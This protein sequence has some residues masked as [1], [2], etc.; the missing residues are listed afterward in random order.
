[1]SW[2]S[3][4]DSVRSEALSAWFEVSGEVVPPI[5]SLQRA[6]ESP[7]LDRISAS[8][9]E[10]ATSP[11][12]RARILASMRKE[13]G[14]WLNALPCAPLGTFLDNGTVRIAASLRLGTKI[15]HP[16]RCRCGEA[17]DELGTHGLSCQKN[18]GRLA[19]HA[20]INDIIRRACSSIHVPSILEPSG[21]YRNDGKRPDGVT[22]MPWSKGKCLLWDAT[23]SDTLAKSYISSTSRSAGAA[24]LSAEKRKHKKYEGV[25]HLYKFVPFAVETLGPFG[26]EAMDLVK[27]LGRRLIESSGELRSRAYLTQRISIAIQRGNAASIFATVPRSSQLTEVFYL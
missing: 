14:A 19:R 12:S 1:M 23:C 26:D 7:T 3:H 24:A 18:A 16:H 9:L 10:G 20:E 4:E 8:L 2:P 21:I 13:S 17:V 5:S 25:A 15:C 22:L 27:D 6:W 11:A